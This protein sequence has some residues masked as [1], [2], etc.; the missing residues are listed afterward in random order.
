MAT[1]HERA[2]KSYTC[3]AAE[4]TSMVGR[5][6][7]LPYPAIPLESSQVTQSRSLRQT[8]TPHSQTLGSLCFFFFRHHHHAIF[9]SP[10]HSCFECPRHHSTPRPPFTT[11]HRTPHPYA[12]PHRLR[13]PITTQPCARSSF[14]IFSAT[15]DAH[16]RKITPTD[17]LVLPPT[18][19]SGTQ[20]F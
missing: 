18:P 9:S 20:P 13:Q 15:N 17:L 6:H 16:I 5:S 19:T 3:T 10:F 14:S 2:T 11:K 12:A 1:I 7:S 4:Q 8:V